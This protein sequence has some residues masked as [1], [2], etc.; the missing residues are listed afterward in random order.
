MRN[1]R[2][3]IYLIKYFDHK[4]SWKTLPWRSQTEVIHLVVMFASINQRLTIPLEFWCLDKSYKNEISILKFSKLQWF[5][6]ISKIL[7][8]IQVLRFSNIRNYQIDVVFNAKFSNL[9]A[10]EFFN[11]WRNCILNQT[12]STKKS[13]LNISIY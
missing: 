7:S 13:N 2:K 6:L 5:L 10:F 3:N 4:N 8:T 11:Y 9:R 12:W 1:I